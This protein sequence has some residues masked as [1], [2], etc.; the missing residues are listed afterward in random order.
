[1]R[2]SRKKDGEEVRYGEEDWMKRKRNG[3]GGEKNIWIMCKGWR[4]GW[5]IEQWRSYMITASIHEVLEN[6]GRGRRGEEGRKD[7]WGTN[8]GGR[9]WRRPAGGESRTM[10]PFCFLSRHKENYWHSES[11]EIKWRKAQRKGEREGRKESLRTTKHYETIIYCDA[12]VGQQ[13][14]RRTKF[15]PLIPF[16]K[17]Y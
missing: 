3:G 13:Y 6:K 2:E 9:G 1:M 8:H 11:E 17:L 15:N 5:W 4:D 12:R 10:L 14:E 7:R 16:K